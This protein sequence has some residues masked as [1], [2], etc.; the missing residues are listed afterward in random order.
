[1]VYKKKCILAFLYTNNLTCIRISILQ[2]L[3][4]TILNTILLQM[5]ILSY[6]TIIQLPLVS[7]S[8]LYSAVVQY[9]IDSIYRIITCIISIIQYRYSTCRFKQHFSFSCIISII[10]YRYSTCRFKQ[11]TFFFFLKNLTFSLESSLFLFCPF[12]SRV[13]SSRT[14]CLV[15]TGRSCTRQNNLERG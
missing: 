1:M 4:D 12:H 14:S 3:I 6:R 9:L 5:L 8:I 15:F 7:Y 10:Q 2:I 11:A 13:S